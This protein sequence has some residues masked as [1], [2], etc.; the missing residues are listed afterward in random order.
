MIKR[1]QL[2]TC[3]SG[4]KY[5]KC[6][7]N[8]NVKK[9][10]VR[11]IPAAERL[12]V[13]GQFLEVPQKYW[14]NRPTVKSG[15]DLSAE[16][17]HLEAIS[18]ANKN[19]L[20]ESKSSFQKSLD[21]Q[22]VPEV[23]FNL[24]VILEKMGLQ[25]D[26]IASLHDA[27]NLRSDFTEA[28]LAL[29]K[30]Y[31]TN[32]DFDGAID[33]YRKAIAFDSTNIEAHVNLGIIC[34]GKGRMD[35]ASTCFNDALALDPDDV[36]LFIFANLARKCTPE[37][38]GQIKRFE[39]K[40]TTGLL[41][42]RLRANLAFNL[43]KAFEELGEYDNAFRYFSEGNRLKRATIN[44]SL[45]SFAEEVES[46]KSH[47]DF[48]H[49]KSSDSGGDSFTPVF[50]IGM[51]RSGTT[52]IEKILASHPDVHGAG[53]ISVVG[54][55]AMKLARTNNLIMIYEYIKENPRQFLEQFSMDY[56]ITLQEYDR[57]VS[58][59]TNK[60]PLN[61]L[62]VGLI[63]LALPNAKII[64]C[65]RDPMD[66]CWSIYKHSFDGTHKYAYDLKEL[67][68]YYLLYEDL[69]AFWH[70]VFPGVIYEISYED[71]VQKQNLETRNL[72]EYCN[73]PWNK[74]CLAFHETAMDIKTASKLQVNKPIYKDSIQFWRNY[75]N[76]LKPLSEVLSR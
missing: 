29:A 61:Y 7:G 34:Q 52:L 30:L 23:F 39:N 43:G 8:A 42:E 37:N 40:F 44:F 68:E 28:Y 59:I 51:P 69:M 70:N 19:R 6:C 15:A 41:P 4:K 50:I 27:V 63:H 62:F 33:S 26:A 5:K 65:Q 75:E 18:Y 38:L 58:H 3:G 16:N 54:D 53:E 45:Q 22:P 35:E 32:K 55:I 49:S 12:S 57:S 56:A 66:T 1:N 31:Q 11:S 67:G 71:L 20:E 76:H 46:I 24:A 73:L 48:F 36:E 14:E 60:M 21:L 74:R 47:G 64:H 25:D 13:I 10:Q 72:L 9:D 2:C 17:H